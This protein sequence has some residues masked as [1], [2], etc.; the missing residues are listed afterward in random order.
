M[1]WFFVPAF[2]TVQLLPVGHPEITGSQPAPAV[3]QAAAAAETMQLL[4]CNTAI[5][6]MVIK[7][8]IRS[9]S[10]VVL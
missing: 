10:F 1:V 7:H 2:V 8:V 5:E 9:F 4:L 3:A 6:L